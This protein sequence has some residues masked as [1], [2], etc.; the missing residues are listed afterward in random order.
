MSFAK[1]LQPLVDA[2]GG[3]TKAAELLGRTRQTI[4]LWLNGSAP[5]IDTQA[6]ALF[7][8]GASSDQLPSRRL[9]I[10]PPKT[11]AQLAAEVASKARLPVFGGPLKASKTK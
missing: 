6:G 8:L 10:S 9:E 7:L 2:A 1:Q 3:P 4:N 11:T 5:N